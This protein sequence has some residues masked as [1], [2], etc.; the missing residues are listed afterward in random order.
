[1]LACEYCG[2]NLWNAQDTASHPIPCRA[3]VAPGSTTIG[4]PPGELAAPDPLAGD[5]ALPPDTAASGLVTMGA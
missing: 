4:V 2:C 5:P 1:M 3:G